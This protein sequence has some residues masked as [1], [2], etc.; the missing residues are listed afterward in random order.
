MISNLEFGG[1]QQQIVALMNN[2]DQDTHEVH[3][4]CLSDFIPLA[5]KLQVPEAR[6]HILK[7]RWKYDVTVPVRLARLLRKIDAD[8]VHG[9]LFDAEIACRIAGTIARTP[10][11][12]GSERNC[13][14]TIKS[15][16]ALFHKL[17]HNMQT[18]CIAN[19]HAGAAFNSDLLGYPADHY[20]VV[21]NGVDTDRF[22]PGDGSALRKE[23]GI[24]ESELVV[25][26]FASFKHQKNHELFFNA[27]ARIMQQLENVR[28]LLVGDELYGGMHGSGDY[29][30]GLQDLV[31][32]L[33]IRDNCIFAGNQSTVEE[34]Y[35]VCDLTV[36]PSRHEGMPNSVLESMASG[37]PVVATRVA[38]NNLLVPDRK[39]G[40]LVES[41]NLE[42][43][44]GAIES[45]LSDSSLRQQFSQESVSWVASNF[46]ATVMSRNMARTYDQMFASI[47]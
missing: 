36:L 13:D 45:L 9:F 34:Y 16:Q 42:E 19:S 21:H 31:D 32:E 6:L 17:T 8:I 18:Y 14:Y 47:T 22:R 44:Q 10:V 2:I 39:A 27:A 35:R 43:L 29:K 12:V 38:D 15:N 20:Y 11:V 7:K 24:S 37:I 1:A 25:G 46:S 3:L 33:K 4:V 28:F 40:L 41:D 30:D 23:L 5:E 26:V